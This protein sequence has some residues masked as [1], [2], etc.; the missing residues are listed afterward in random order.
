[1]N[2][3]NEALYANVSILL[4]DGTGS[5]A[6]PASFRVGTRPDFVATADFNGD[7]YLDLAVANYES[8]DVSILLGTGTGTFGS[9]INLGLG[10]V[11]GS[12][13]IGDLNGDG[14][15]DLAV[16]SY[17]DYR[18]EPYVPGGVSILLGT[19]TGAFGAATNLAPGDGFGSVAVGD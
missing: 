1:D 11:P 18:A 4:G 19:G 7:G 15:L 6:A 13:A 9:A 12:V 14:H 10:S 2:P 16:T 3:L 8:K 5:F 17:A